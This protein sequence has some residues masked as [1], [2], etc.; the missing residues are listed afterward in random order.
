[1]SKVFVPRPQQFEQAAAS[2][3]WVIQHNLGRTVGADV[4][5]A[6]EQGVYQKVIPQEIIKVDSNSIKVVFPWP[7]PNK[8]AT[9]W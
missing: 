6:D 3:E 9:V 1:M 5:I 7:I 2:A 8:K 4:F